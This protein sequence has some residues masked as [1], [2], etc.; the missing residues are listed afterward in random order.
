LD[1]SPRSK[2]EITTKFCNDLSVLHSALLYNKSTIHESSTKGIQLERGLILL[3][4]E[5]HPIDSRQPRVPK[6]TQESFHQRTKGSMV[7][8]EIFIDRYQRR[9][10]PV[11]RI[12]IDIIIDLAPIGN[13]PLSEKA[14]IETC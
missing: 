14:K 8:P 12:D 11:L 3:V 6:N 7:G 1:G 9:Q 10:I 4:R 5:R 2:V 13:C